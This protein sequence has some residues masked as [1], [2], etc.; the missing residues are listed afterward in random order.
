MEALRTF[1][2][3]HTGHHLVF[4]PSE[5]HSFFAEIDADTQPSYWP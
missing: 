3:E 1:L 5:E 2:L 4:E